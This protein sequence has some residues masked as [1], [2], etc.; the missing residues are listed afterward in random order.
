MASIVKDIAA[1]VAVGSFIAVGWF[2]L[3]VLVP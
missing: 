2:W 1:A 3:M